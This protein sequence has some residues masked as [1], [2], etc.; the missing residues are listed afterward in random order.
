MTPTM[1]RTAIA[2]DHPIY[3]NRLVRSLEDEADIVVVGEGASA[4][5]AIA[6][7]GDKK[8]DAILVDLSM[9]GGGH[10]AL[11]SILL[12]DPSAAVIVLTA[13]EERDDLLAAIKIGARGYVLKGVDA[14]T[15][16]DIVRRVVAGESYVSSGLAARILVEMKAPSERPALADGDPSTTLASLTPREEQV[17]GLVAAGNSNKEIA[18]HLNL[19]EKTVKHNMTRILQKLR[20]RNRTEAAMFLRNARNGP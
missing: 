2:D 3:R 5:D 19:Q 13:S 1:L 9:P 15:L 18:R 11:S 6:L 8:P 4:E 10:L 20:A 17:F 7:Y 16:V 14:P 12:A